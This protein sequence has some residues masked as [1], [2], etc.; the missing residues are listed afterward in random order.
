NYCLFGLPTGFERRSADA[1]R[2]LAVDEETCPLPR[3]TVLQGR[4]L[5]LAR[6]NCFRCSTNKGITESTLSLIRVVR[7]WR[8]RS[9]AAATPSEIVDHHAAVAR[10]G[11]KL[12]PQA[13]VGE[14]EQ[15]VEERRERTG[16][17]RAQHRTDS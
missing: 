3:D 17:E 16:V 2:P 11:G 14:I 8:E 15:G 1:R 12:R 9:G 10:I 6:F 4:P 7:F 5:P 13:V